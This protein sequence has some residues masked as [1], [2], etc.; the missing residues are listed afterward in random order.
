MRGD[1][2]AAI[3]IGAALGFALAVVLVRPGNC[4]ERVGDAVHERVVEGLGE[5]A[6]DV[7][8]AVGG[9]KWSPGVV[10]FFGA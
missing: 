2:V 1:V 4:C 8:D 9:R 3:A 5:F 6:G 7:F 10:N